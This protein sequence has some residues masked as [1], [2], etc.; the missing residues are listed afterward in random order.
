MI[1]RRL[2]L[3]AGGILVWGGGIAAKLASLQLLHY[4]EYREIA[5]SRQEITVEI[6]GPRGAIYD[7]RGSPLALS[8]PAESIFV[9]PLRVPDI[10][11]ASAI[12]S[13]ILNLD[14]AAIFGKMKWAQEHKRGF[15]WIKRKISYD[16][17]QRLRSLQVD[18]IETESESVR[19]YPKG[20]IA[21]HVI[22]SVD[23]EQAGNAGIEKALEQELHGE[24]GEEYVLTDVK[25]R[26]IRSQ[27][28]SQAQPGAAITL[29]IDEHLQ[30]IAQKE[31]ALAV[32]AANAER[33]SAVGM[34]PYTGE[35]LFMASYP[36]FDPSKPPA[37]GE[38]RVVRQNQCIEAPFEP[39]SVFKVITLSAALETTSLRPQTPIN[40]LGGRITLFGRTIHE[41]HHGYGTIPMEMVLA[42]SSNIGAIQ[43]GMRVG[44]ENLREYI[45][46]FGFGQ[47]TGIPLPAESGGKVRRK[48]GKTS[49][50]SV[51]MGHE[52]STTTLQLAQACAVV[53]NGG[54]LVKPRLVIRKNGQ[55]VPIA[56]PTQVLKPDNAIT[57]RQMM[58]TVVLKGTG[59]RARLQGYTSGGKTGSAQIYDPK[60]GHFT[61]S[62]NASYM[63]FA[64]VQNPAIVIV[65]TLNGTHGS[66]GFG[67]VVAAPVFRVLAQETLRVLEVPRDI[68]EDE[69]PPAQDKEPI[70]DLSIADLGSDEPTVM[71][72]MADEERLAT[73][74]GPQPPPEM[75]PKGPRVPN[76][77][78]KTM[79]AVL[80][81]AAER[82]LPVAP[83]GSGIAKMQYPPPGAVLRE[84]ERIRVRFSR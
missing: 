10:A 6:P 80:A 62:Y 52:L 35:V 31:L 51:A 18:W 49:L 47:R 26:L 38:P 53:A 78:G 15:L 58:E 82:G 65:V 9:N 57:M 22:G 7:R 74:Q 19:K 11:V 4:R 70:D 28:A 40:C 41:A 34:N 14:R 45:R 66:S 84:G 37:P 83:D 29:S 43:V 56:S 30:Y 23:F 55:P 63:G 5:R 61:H 73:P 33:G 77:Q 67:G 81:E 12:L 39:G 59:S 27:Q 44:E 60:A 48:W 8:I 24:H 3:L 46:R 36:S 25:R 64:P 68:P 79:R 71:Q 42:K 76:F 20:E 13:D 21:A 54:M 69:A 1:E 75:Q 50:S 2:T 72:E 16:E 17:A 32:R